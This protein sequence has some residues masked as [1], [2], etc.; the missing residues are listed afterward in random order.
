M[1]G[2]EYEEDK[3]T[4]AKS[5]RGIAGGSDGVIVS[6]D[7]RNELPAVGG[8]CGGV[9]SHGEQGRALQQ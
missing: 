1:K 6:A 9:H 7:S 4:G 2:K 3:R 8:M 5:G